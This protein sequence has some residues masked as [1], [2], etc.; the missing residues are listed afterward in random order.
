MY[1]ITISRLKYDSHNF[2]NISRIN[3]TLLFVK[4]IIKLFLS[5]IGGKTCEKTAKTSLAVCLMLITFLKDVMCAILGFNLRI[6][7]RNFSTENRQ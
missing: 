7:T 5:L 4:K 3:S 2:K 1:F 6:F